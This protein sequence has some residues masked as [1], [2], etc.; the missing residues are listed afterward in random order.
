MIGFAVEL[1]CPDCRAFFGTITMSPTA[2][3]VMLGLHCRTRACRGKQQVVFY[4]DAGRARAL[5]GD[6]RAAIVAG[7]EG[8]L[9]NAPDHIG[10]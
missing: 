10:G 9:A 2:P 3:G 6:E 8:A 4:V 5:T 1:R 7:Q